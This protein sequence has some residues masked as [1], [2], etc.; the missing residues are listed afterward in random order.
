MPRRRDA[1]F[2]LLLENMQNVNGLWEPHG[3]DGPERIAPE[4]GNNNGSNFVTGAIVTYYDPNNIPYSAKAAS[5]INSGQI[6]DTAFDD[7]AE[8][9]TWKVTVTNQGGSPS[10]PFSCN[11]H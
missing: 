10:A 5:V 11:V 3:I 2:G 8:V 4:V 7:A 6:V 9:G 1:P